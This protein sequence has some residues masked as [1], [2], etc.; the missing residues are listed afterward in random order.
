VQV[1]TPCPDA[2]EVVLV[3]MDR[4]DMVVEWIGLSRT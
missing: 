1:E 2:C 4:W 3:D